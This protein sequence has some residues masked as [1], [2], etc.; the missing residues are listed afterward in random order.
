MDV[1]LIVV[2]WNV[3][4]YLLKCVE[5]I[6]KYTENITFEIIVVD[7]ASNDGSI[8]AL[9]SAYTQ[10]ILDEKL[11]II[12]NKNNNGF[13]KANNQGLKEARGKYIY[14]VNPDVE[15]L[16]NTVIKL[17]EYMDIH[18]EVGI[19]TGTLLYG[20]K[21]TQPNVKFN[22]TFCDQVIVLLKLHHFLKLKCLK[23]YLAKDFDYHSPSE[24]QLIMGASMF[25]RND[26][27]K[28]IQ[29]WDED[30]WIWW[31]DVDLCLRVQKRKLK[32]MYLP[33]TEM[34]HY[35]S[36]SFE[37][38]MSLQKQKRFITG[39]LTYFKKH[40]SKAAYFALLILSPI[41]Y[42]LAYIVQILKI[43]PRTQSRI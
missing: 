29:G 3:R 1:S 41:S 19:C 32:I 35:E 13:S 38:V 30:Y 36:K 34:I 33:I 22:P 39:M 6:F 4:E 42:L 26:L 18:P 15:F 17:K 27:M 14:F 16:E 28:A 37:K 31:E 9:R 11:V 23:R 7:N 21:T 24:V 8:E 20:D 10:E 12:N 40:H 5:S 43:K 2:N 25:T